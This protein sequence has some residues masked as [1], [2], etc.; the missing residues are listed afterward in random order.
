MHIACVQS[1]FKAKISR[2]AKNIFQNLDVVTHIRVKA[3]FHW[4]WS[5]KSKQPQNTVLLGFPTLQTVHAKCVTLRTTQNNTGFTS[6]VIFAKKTQKKPP[7][8]YLFLYPDSNVQ[9]SNPQSSLINTLCKILPT[10]RHQTT[11]EAK[12]SLMLIYGCEL[13]NL[14]G[15]MCFWLI[16]FIVKMYYVH[17]RKKPLLI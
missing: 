14:S 3:S 5:R 4:M 7:S 2:L 10:F 6:P 15:C 1:I 11:S 9:Q 17:R 16:V 8:V 12:L 13:L